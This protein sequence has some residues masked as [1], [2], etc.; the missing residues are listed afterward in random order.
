MWA[1]PKCVDKLIQISAHDCASKNKM[2]EVKI[3][4]QALRN[5]EGST[6]CNLPSRLT[7]VLLS[8]TAMYDNNTQVWRH[9]TLYLKQAK[10]WK[11]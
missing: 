2:F 3:Q 8:L 4:R 5:I 6:T 9:V 1:S 7:C 11:Q 10:R